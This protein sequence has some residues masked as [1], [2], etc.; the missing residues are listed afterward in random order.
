MGVEGIGA[1]VVR[2]EDKRFITGKGRYV[3]QRVGSDSLA[4]QITQG[5][6]AFRRVL[7]P[8]QRQ[9]NTVIR[10]ALLIVIYME[11]LLVVT[12]IVRVVPTAD[13]VG[14]A[15]VLAGPTG[16]RRRRLRQPGVERVPRWSVPPRPVGRR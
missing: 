12:S 5:A 6:K 15:A 9:V 16:G 11:L 3:V 13:A 4:N 10:L 2:K 7:T 1:R 8:L 14:Q